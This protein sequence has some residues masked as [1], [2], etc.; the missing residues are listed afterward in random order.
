VTA[1]H[2]RRNEARERK[3]PWKKWVPYL[4]ERQSR[5]VR[6]DNSEDGDAWN[7]FTHDQAR[8]LARLRAYRWGAGRPGRHLFGVH[9]LAGAVNPEKTVTKAELDRGQNR[10]ATS[11][12]RGS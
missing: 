10:S 3:V 6:E 4:S 1:E 5:T 8:S 11:L 2:A 9:G 12:A 7:D